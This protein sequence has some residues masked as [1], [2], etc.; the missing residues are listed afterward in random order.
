MQL[1][2]ALAALGIIASVNA[3]DINLYGPFVCEGTYATCRNHAQDKCC[4]HPR[5]QY[6]SVKFDYLPA[7]W[8]LQLRGYQG[9]SCSRRTKTLRSKGFSWRCFY[10]GPFTGAGYG[11]NNKKRGEIG[12]SA[13]EDIGECQVPDVLVLQDG[14]EY[15]LKGV[16]ENT[17]SSIFESLGDIITAHDIPGGAEDLRLL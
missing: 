8:D 17:I 6:N 4:G 5:L 12:G 2:T 13:Q 11:F 7:E 3:I 9:G 10:E 16:D 15:S 1:T 14:T